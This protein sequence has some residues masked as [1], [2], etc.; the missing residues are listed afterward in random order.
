MFITPFKRTNTQPHVAR[1]G[2][3]V[4]VPH[5]DCTNGDGKYEIYRPGDSAFVVGNNEQQYVPGEPLC[6]VCDQASEVQASEVQ[7]RGSD[8]LECEGCMGAVHFHCAALSEAPEVTIVQK[9]KQSAE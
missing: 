7:E 5:M 2:R 1:K 9:T 8:L 6:L 4:T 3:W